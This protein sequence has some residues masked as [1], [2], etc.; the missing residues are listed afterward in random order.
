MASRLRLADYEY[1]IV[2]KPGKIDKNADALSRNP[3]PQLIFSL[4]ISQ[5]TNA[6]SF[7][8]STVSNNQILEDPTIVD[9]CNKKELYNKII[10][11]DETSDKTDI[12]NNSDTKQNDA[13]E[14]TDE[15][16]KT[17]EVNIV[18]I[19]E[20]FINR[21]ENLVFFIN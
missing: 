13:P 7:C 4:S 10:S 15:S 14:S 20:S 3:I 12:T 17:N 16:W 21:K 19:P 6:K 8:Q 11:S 2:Y 18:E 9:E 5:E 1:E